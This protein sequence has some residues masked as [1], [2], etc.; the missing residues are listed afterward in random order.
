MVTAKTQTQIDPSSVTMSFMGHA[1][2]ACSGFVPSDE[3]PD[4]EKIQHFFHILLPSFS[5]NT[6]RPQRKI[7]VFRII[8]SLQITLKL[9]SNSGFI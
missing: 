6:F 7:V 2:C 4:M 1:D 9:N 8:R 5:G 3:W